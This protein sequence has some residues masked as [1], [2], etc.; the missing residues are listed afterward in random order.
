MKKKKGIIKEKLASIF[1]LPP[2]ATTGAIRL[3][4]LNNTDLFLENHQGIKEYTLDRIRI[5]TAR[6]ELVVRGKNLE[7][8]NMGAENIVVTGEIAAI[9][10]EGQGV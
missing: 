8:K 7:L 10:F 6:H 5:H 4:L 3:I 9:E 1:E 2:E